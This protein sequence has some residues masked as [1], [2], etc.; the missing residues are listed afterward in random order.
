[1]TTTWTPILDGAI[2]DSALQTVGT[3]AEVLSAPPVSPGGEST[4]QAVE[5]PSLACGQS[6]LA[7]LFAYLAQAGLVD[8]GTVISERC[9][10]GAA[11][12]VATTQ[13]PPSLYGGF[14]GVAWA[15]AHLEGREGDDGDSSEEIDRALLE[16]LARSPWRDDY[17]LI[18]GLV[19]FGVYARE[20]LPRA[21]ATELLDR[22]VERLEETA[23]RGDDGATWH[24]PP[25]LLP[26]WQR[27]QCPD[28]YYNVGLAHGVPG[29]VAILGGA[30]AAGVARKTARRLLDDSVRWLLAQKLAK[31]SG[32]LF[33]T[34]VARGRMS[35]PSRSAW[36]YGDPGIAAALLCAARSVGEPAWEREALEIARAAAGRP[37]DQAGVRDAGLCHGAAGLG[38][39]F[40]RMFQATGDGHLREAA[41][42]WLGRALDMRK[43]R[44]GV[45]GYQ[46]YRLDDSP[47]PFDPN[48]GIL[49]GA[50]GI[51]LALLAAV[52]PI[53]P[54]WDRMLLLS[55]P[56]RDGATF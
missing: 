11:D 4:A 3:I 17:D 46:A 47:P 49:E 34:C 18:S 2:A 16:L 52:S 1:M 36:C 54:E 30:V 33:P 48:Y 32:S 14:A 37:P 21:S 10:D 27:E 35:E 51:A 26:P 50:A 13:L 9:L 40:N 8:G 12:A 29:V 20:R 28:G 39:I 5:E 15:S 31:D 44:V 23:E 43:P 25:E 24:T 45:G 38:H 7:V 41:R 42:F 22:V 55:M 56:V 6:G 19:G 53:E